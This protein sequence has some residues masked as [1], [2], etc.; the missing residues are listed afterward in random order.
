M[1]QNVLRTK[2]GSMLPL[3]GQ[4]CDFMKCYYIFLE[5]ILAC[6]SS[7]GLGFAR[8]L[9]EM[10][11]TDVLHLPIYPKHLEKE[12]KPPKQKNYVSSWSKPVKSLWTGLES[13]R[14]G[15]Y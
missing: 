1:K 5:G 4:E 12:Q 8:Q 9:V 13:V 14:L 6:F 11:R 3:A 7:P 15:R 2:H 10:N